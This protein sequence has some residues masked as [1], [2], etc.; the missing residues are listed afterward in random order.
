MNAFGSDLSSSQDSYSA[1]VKPQQIKP[2]LFA[3]IIVRV[4]DFSS[5]FA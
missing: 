1:S 2:E 5:H 3:L 4:E